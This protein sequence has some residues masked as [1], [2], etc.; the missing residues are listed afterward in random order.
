MKKFTALALTLGLCLFM[1]AGCGGGDTAATSST[2]ESSAAAE[3]SATEKTVTDISGRE[4]TIPAEVTSI[5]NLW[6]AYT[7]SFYVIGAGDLLAAQAQQS[8]VNAWTEFFYPGAVDVPGMGGTTPNVEEIVSLDPDLVIVHPTSIASGYADQLTELGVPALDLNFDTYAGMIDSYTILG[9]ALGGEYQ[10]KLDKLC[11]DVQEKLDRNRD[12]TADI[13]EEDKPVVYYI[14]GQ[15]NSLTTTMLGEDT[16]QE[17]WTV[18]NGGIYAPA[19]MTAGEN[20][21]EV[22]AEEVFA[23][24]PDVIMVGGTNQHSLIEQLQNTEGWK[25]LNA[26]KNGRV[27]NIPYGCFNWE[28]FGIESDLMIDYA[29]YCIQPE[30]AEEHGI[31]HDYL[32]QEI[33]DFY[34]T[35]NGTE[36][37]TE[38]AENML[39]GLTPDGQDEAELMAAQGGNQGGQGGAQ[40]GGQG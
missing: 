35:Y 9:Q 6:P 30:I 33:I 5:V 12:W 22:T 16:M 26:V 7:S 10:E 28:R 1:F 27:Y 18:S 19:S 4:V 38:Q 32:V 13:P 2:G 8:N 17:D 34:K 31:D 37:T 24:N 15:T 40:G 3:S 25:D 14:A 23:Q 39:A 29:L 36:M 21:Q 20:A 11:A